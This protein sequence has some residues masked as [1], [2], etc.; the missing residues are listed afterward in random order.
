MEK[1]CKGVGHAYNP[2]TWEGGQ[3]D[4]EFEPRLGNRAIR[5]LKTNKQTK[6]KVTGS[7]QIAALNLKQTC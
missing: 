6:T 5:S 2:S 1:I 3:E 7:N 4:I